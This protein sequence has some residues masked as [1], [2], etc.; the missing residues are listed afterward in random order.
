MAKNQTQLNP[1][2]TVAGMGGVQ[3][4]RSD[5]QFVLI[6]NPS[7]A[8]LHVSEVE[9]VVHISRGRIFVFRDKNLR[10][11]KHILG[12]KNIC[13][14]KKDKCHN[15]S[16][17]TL[18]PLNTSLAMFLLASTT[19]SPLSSRAMTGP[20]EVRYKSHNPV[21]NSSP[22]SYYTGDFHTYL[23]T[24]QL[25]SYSKIQVSLLNA[26]SCNCNTHFGYYI[27]VLLPNL[28]VDSVDFCNVSCTT[29]VLGKRL[30]KVE[31][32]A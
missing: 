1:S 24:V 13:K 19:P 17:I 21:Y 15:Y 14:T 25:H 26:K 12:Y 5:E 10:R 9:E 28:S 22:N 29:L 4:I 18:V 6:L 30:E 8:H 20:L 3:K 11:K 32:I 27:P 23:M 7:Q 31:K 16:A 2:W